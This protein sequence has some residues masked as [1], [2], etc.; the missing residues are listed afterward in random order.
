[1]IGL[2]H[3][4]APY[5]NGLFAAGFV[6]RN[7]AP[8]VVH[9]AHGRPG[10]AFGSVG[11]HAAASATGLVVGYAIGLGIQQACAPR[12]PCRNGFRD[13]PPGLA[14]GAVAG[15]V[16]G[17]VLDALVLARRPRSSWESTHTGSTFPVTIVPYATARAQGLAAAGTF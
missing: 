12:D 6:G 1:M 15:S 17:T 11:L 2:T 16:V 8:A 3:P 9:L 14:Y 7:V 10:L 4:D 5:G 13:V